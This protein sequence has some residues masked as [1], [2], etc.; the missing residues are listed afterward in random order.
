[1]P[2]A[3]IARRVLKSSLFDIKVVSL[4]CSWY[5]ISSLTSQ[6]TKRILNDFDFPVFVGEFQFL[7]S[8]LLG[9][10]TIFLLGRFPHLKSAILGSSRSGTGFVFNRRLLRVFFPMG[11]FQFI[12]KLLSLAATS[13]CPVATVSSIRALG[14][15]LTVMGYRIYYKVRFPSYTYLSLIPLVLGVVIIVV[16]Q[17]GDKDSTRGT[18]SDPQLSSQEDGEKTMLRVMLLEKS[19]YLKGIAFAFASAV[20]FAG[21]SIYAKNVVTPSSYSGARDPG[22]LAISRGSSAN[23][24]VEKYAASSEHP[25]HERSG[26]YESALEKP[27]KLTTLIYCATYGMLYSIPAFITYECY[28]LFF[29]VRKVSESTYVPNYSC[30]PWTML[31][32]NGISHFG[33]SLLAFHILALLPTVTYSIAAM[34]KR[35]V[36][37][38]VSMI[39][40]GKRLSL[41]EITGLVHVAIGLYCYDRWGSKR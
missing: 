14:P 19:D 37:I 20:I 1:M 15:L 33:Q 26:E 31:V 23:S 11:T 9:H 38:S 12:G 34:M 10:I 3:E 39:I 7:C 41:L 16:S 36:I 35:I 21:Q 29:G 5:F 4:C 2:V 24:D 32:L 25:K 13:L 28:E 6:L 18:I 17:S 22:S 8:L 40:T 30:I 27:D